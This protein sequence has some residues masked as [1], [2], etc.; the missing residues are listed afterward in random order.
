MKIIGKIELPLRSNGWAHEYAPFFITVE[1]E[2]IILKNDNL[3]KAGI[4]ITQTDFP[5]LKSDLISSKSK[6]NIPVKM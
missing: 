6:S 2:N 3:P 4:E 1:H 5:Y